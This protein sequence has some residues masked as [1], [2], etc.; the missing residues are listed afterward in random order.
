MFL[1][2]RF[3]HQE[4]EIKMFTKSVRIVV[5]LAVVVGIVAS[6]GVAGVAR[7]APPSVSAQ[8]LEP[9]RGPEPQPLAMPALL[10]PP[11]S[12]LGVQFVQV[13]TGANISAN[14]TSI[15][16]PLTNGNPN[17]IIFVTPNYNPGGVGGTY[18]DHTISVWYTLGS[19]RIFN[20][21]TVA[22]PVGAAFNVFIPPAGANVFVHTAI[23]GNSSYNVTTID[24]P[25]TNGNPN[26]IVFVTPNYNP[27]GVCPCVI[28]NHPI[29]VQ[30]DGSKWGIVN[31]DLASM[32]LNASFNVF[33]LSTGAGIFTHTATVSNT[34]FSTTAIDNSL[35]NGKPNAIVFAMPNLTPGGI[36]SCVGDSRNIGVYYNGSKWSILYQSDMAISVNAAFNVLVLVPTSAVFVHK[37]TVANSTSDWTT[38]DNALTNGHPNAVAFVTPNYNPGGVGGTTNPHPINVWYTGSQWAISNQDGVTP[39][40]VNAAFNVLVPNP[41]TSVF[42]H[43]ATT[44]NITLGSET[45]INHP[46]TNGNSNA[47]IFVIPNYNP[48]GVGGIVDPYPISVWYYSGKW[49]IINY[50]G[51]I[52]VDTMF[53]VFVPSPGPNVFIHTATVANTYSDWTVIDNPLTNGKPNA[54]VIVTPNSNSGMFENH[55][56][57]VWYNGSQWAISNQ[58]GSAPMQVGMTFNVYVNTNRLY[59]PLILR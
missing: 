49:G 24:N 40:P 45:W 23:G 33:V 44:T 46:L 34:T 54:M 57:N 31:R 11:A 14:T 39:I 21:D 16:H 56:V 15:D 51:N 17:A 2:H 48:G 27:D 7:G 12:S 4:G 41:D 50:T 55:Q 6:A 36:C 58:D 10:I 38:I 28:D 47:I 1:Q 3:V 20:Q 37:A 35:T 9:S 43:R 18:V 22:M 42:V 25:L 59:L 19:W 29:A 32:P 52:Q 8:N 30:Y 26:A 5:V 53:N 13:A